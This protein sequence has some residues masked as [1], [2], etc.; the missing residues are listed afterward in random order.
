LLIGGTSFGA[1]FAYVSG[2]AFVFVDVFKVDPR[3]Y[4]ALFAVNAFAIAIGAFVSGRLSTRGVSANRLIMVGLVISFGATAALFG[5]ALL[6]WLNVFSIMPLLILN[7]FSMGLVTPN[8]VHGALEPMPRIAGVASSAFGSI[9]M[10]GGAISSEVV[11]LWYHGT[12]VAMGATMALFA[13]CALLI[14]VLLVRQRAEGAADA[15]NTVS[16]VGAQ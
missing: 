12:P 7:T 9:R 14:G 13:A 15:V 3:I 5:G 6:G 8:A 11:A 16:A 4:G 10:F 2:S 1:L